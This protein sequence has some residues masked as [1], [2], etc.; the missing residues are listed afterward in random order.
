MLLHIVA[1]RYMEGYLISYLAELT[2]VTA[3]GLFAG[4]FLYVVALSI[5]DFKKILIGRS[6]CPLCRKQLKWY[7]LIPIFSYII[8]FGKCRNCSKKISTQYF[9]V[10]LATAFVYGLTYA[11][12]QPILLWWQ[13]IILLVILSL[14]VVIYLYDAKTMY[15][16]DHALYASF[17]LTVLWQLS[18]GVA[19]LSTAVLAAIIAAAILF[20]LRFIASRLV[21]QEAMGVGDIYIG[22]MIG[23]LVGLPHI[24]VAIFL[25]FI[26]G[27]LMG[28]IV[29]LRTSGRKNK[30][31]SI[32]FAP[33]LILGGFV[34][35]LYGQQIVNWY[36]G[37][38]I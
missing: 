18:R 6:A 24:Y 36:L 37:Y 7:E 38:Y 27:S 10:E 19:F 17:V 35:L 8:Q 34:S 28:I 22:A 12:M 20:V 21:K 5:P 9:W 30:Y 26:I 33:A 32:P 29:L 16:F 31:T 15:I 13:M 23:L 3:I 14:W 1:W 11:V 25:S 2:I 4:S